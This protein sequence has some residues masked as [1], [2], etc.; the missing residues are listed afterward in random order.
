[1]RI[2]V[3]P[4]EIILLHVGAKNVKSDIRV[5]TTNLCGCVHVSFQEANRVN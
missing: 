4:S 3:Y 2:I 1:M 5:V